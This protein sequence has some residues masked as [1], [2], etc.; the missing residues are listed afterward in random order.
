M[1]DGKGW[2]VLSKD[3]N[4]GEGRP[5]EVEELWDAVVAAVGWYDHPVWPETEGLDELRQRGLAKH[6]KWWHGPKGYGGKVK[7]ST[8]IMPSFSSRS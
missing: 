7:I 3:W 2:S 6:A 4:K 1:K 5:R 8:H